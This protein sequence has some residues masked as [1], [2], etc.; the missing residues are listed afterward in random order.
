MAVQGSVCRVT[1]VLVL[2]PFLVLEPFRQST[3]VPV[4]NLQLA[5]VSA[6]QNSSRPRIFPLQSPQDVADLINTPLQRGVNRGEDM[7]TVSTVLS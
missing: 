1:F 5:T 3:C 6:G 2:A 7:A 4:F